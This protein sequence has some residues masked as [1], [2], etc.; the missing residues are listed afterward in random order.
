[1]RINICS[2]LVVFFL[3]SI[4]VSA[5]YNQ[6]AS[7]LP[8]GSNPMENISSELTVISK[9]VRNLSESMKVFLDKFGG[10]AANDKHQR[11]LAGLQILNEAEQRLGT[12]QKLQ[13]DLTEKQIPAKTR[14]IQIDQ[15]L[16]PESIDRSATFLGTTKTDEFRENR[17]RSLETEKR[18]L[19]GLLAQLDI[20]IAQTRSE[21]SEAQS[22]VARLRRKF[23]PLIEQ[24]LSEI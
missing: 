14:I 2:L 21:V 9:S 19:Q 22:L 24:T 15:E 23:L 7:Q 6:P 17:R 18:E 12:L 8:P 3:G 20:T 5:Q 11:I 1:M 4:C 16:R 10:A 13:I